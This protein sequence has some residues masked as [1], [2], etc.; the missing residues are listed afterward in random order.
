MFKFNRSIYLIMKYLKHVILLNLNFMI[1]FSHHFFDE[2]F[3][4][5]FKC[6]IFYNSK[7]ICVNFK[8]KWEVYVISSN[9]KGDQSIFL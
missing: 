9:F 3:K 4:F 8:I 1:I 7:K 5:R 2:K 6:Y